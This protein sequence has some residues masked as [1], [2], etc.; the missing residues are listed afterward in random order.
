MTIEE[1]IDHLFNSFQGIDEKLQS[2]QDYSVKSLTKRGKTRSGPFKASP[3][4]SSSPGRTDMLVCH[5]ERFEINI[6][7]LFRE[8]FGEK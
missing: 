5:F 7:T 8:K 1:K 2:W 3:K 4:R 6:D